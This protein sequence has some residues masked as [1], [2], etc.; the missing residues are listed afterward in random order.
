VQ[1]EVHRFAIEYHRQ[2]RGKAM[3]R[4]ELDAAPGRGPKRR[5]ALLSEFGSLERIKSATEEELSRAPGMTRTAARKLLAH[6]EDSG[7]QSRG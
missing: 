4:S 1:E 6:F 3:L 7:P 5:A 2:A